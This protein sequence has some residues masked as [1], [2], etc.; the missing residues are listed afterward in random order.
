MIGASALLLA[1][2]VVASTPAPPTV[3]AA[4]ARL[5]LPPSLALRDGDLVFRRGNDVLAGLVLSRNQGARFSHVGM[6]VFVD[7]KPQVVHATPSEPGSAGGVHLDSLEAFASPELA[8]DVGFYRVKDL[9][10]A[11]ARVAREFVLSQIG[12]P[13]DLQF[14]YA[15][16]AAQYCTELVLKALEQ[17]NVRVAAAL[18]KIH[19]LTM[20]ESAFAPDD[21]QRFA[22]LTEV[23]ST[24]R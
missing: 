21:L 7:G 1:A 5:M 11:G 6:L 14:E 2:A 19:V 20:S 13:F 4:P 15:D 9:D 3:A 18:P 12:K 23:L 22:G 24:T 8:V 16:D 17:A 10:A